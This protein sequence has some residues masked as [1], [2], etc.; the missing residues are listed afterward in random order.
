MQDLTY[1]N[2]LLDEAINKL[3]ALKS[4]TYIKMRF[5]FP[6]NRVIQ[7]KQRYELDEAVAKILG[8]RAV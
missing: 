8:R 5:K 3:T 2:N 7:H 1:V 4:P 6:P